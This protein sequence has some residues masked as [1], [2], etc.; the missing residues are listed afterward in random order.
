MDAQEVEDVLRATG[1]EDNRVIRRSRRTKDNEM[2][3][4]STKIVHD[5]DENGCRHDDRDEYTRE[6]SKKYYSDK[7]RA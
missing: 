3:D 1:A 5:R 4:T 7:W 2:S 6:V